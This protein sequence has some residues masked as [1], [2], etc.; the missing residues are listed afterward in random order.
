MRKLKLLDDKTLCINF[1]RIGLTVI[2]CWIE[3]NK[4][5]KRKLFNETRQYD[6]FFS[7]DKTIFFKY[8]TKQIKATETN[9]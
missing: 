6:I 2:I 1:L 4:V 9:K 8:R 5:K 3:T 7:L